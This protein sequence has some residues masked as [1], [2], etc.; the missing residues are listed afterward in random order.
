MFV[1]MSINPILSDGYIKNRCKGSESR[2]QYKIKKGIFLYLLL[3]RSLLYQKVVEVEDNTKK[4]SYFL[5][6]TKKISNFAP[7][8]RVE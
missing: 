5:V 7:Q 4:M 6:V 1:F 3:R 8:I 2:R